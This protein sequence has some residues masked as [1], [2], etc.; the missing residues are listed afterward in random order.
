MEIQ[1]LG[2]LRDNPDAYPNEIEDK[3]TIEPISLQEIA[4]LEQLCNNG[5]PFPKALK[6]LLFLAGAS[7]YVLDYG[8]FDTQKELQEYVKEKM[9]LRNRTISRP[10]YAIDIYD[11][12]QFFFIYLDEGDNP[13]VYEAIYEGGGL[14]FPDWIHPLNPKSISEL[15][16]QRI[17]RQKE[18]R[19]PF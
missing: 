15:I 12:E 9:V 1:Y 5:N 4:S 8:V 2:Y 6:E 11:T 16:N 18:G 10:F 19:N 7:C 17:D 14:D 13:K 3:L